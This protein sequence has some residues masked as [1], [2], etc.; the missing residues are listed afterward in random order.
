VLTCVDSYGLQEGELFHLRPEDDPRR[1]AE[2][3]KALHNELLKLGRRLGFTAR[4]GRGWE[5]RWLDGTE[6]VYRFTLSATA[7]LGRY[8]L[9]GQPTGAV[10]QRCLV[11][12]GGRARLVNF[13]LQRDARLTQ[14][15]ESGQWQ[16]LKFR[17]LRH[18]LAEKELDRH[19]LKSTLGLDPLVEQEAAQ[20][21]LF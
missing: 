19:I 20:M 1:R 9:A 5:V 16:F 13:R 12:P 8:L 6:E 2:E 10:A 21:P 4:R 18:L 7:S 11:L 17:H 3:I 15:L 14:A